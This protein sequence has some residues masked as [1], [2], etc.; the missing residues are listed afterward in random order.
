MMTCTRA[1]RLVVALTAASAVAVCGVLFLR[2]RVEIFV[3]PPLF[4]EVLRLHELR[5]AEKA[6]ERRQELNEKLSRAA[7]EL[8]RLQRP[9]FERGSD[10][11]VDS[12]KTQG[13]GRAFV[14]AYRGPEGPVATDPEVLD[15]G[16]HFIA[17]DAGGRLFG[18]DFQVPPWPSGVCAYQGHMKIE[19]AG[20][21]PDI[22]AVPG[23]AGYFLSV[24]S[25]GIVPRGAVPQFMFPAPDLAAPRVS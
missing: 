23:D 19:G 18:A 6:V 8:I 21:G 14:I 25:R 2:H 3:L 12:V 16:L 24:D 10:F 4:R 17:A 1:Q 11:R 5:G 22:L 7:G 9:E 15:A 20:E 13:G